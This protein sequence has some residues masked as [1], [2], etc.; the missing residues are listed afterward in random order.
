M[1]MAP[2]AK[3]ANV[4]RLDHQDRKD[5]LEQKEQ[6]VIQVVR[7]SPVMMDSLDHKEKRERWDQ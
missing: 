1:N 6:L 5:H 2:K 3:R 4:E 7:D